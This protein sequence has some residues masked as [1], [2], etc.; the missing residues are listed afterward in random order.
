MDNAKIIAAIQEVVEEVNSGQ[1]SA[2][3]VEAKLD[4][5]ASDTN[6]NYEWV[7]MKFNELLG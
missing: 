1:I 2:T 6:T 5:I 3:E 7:L 4:K